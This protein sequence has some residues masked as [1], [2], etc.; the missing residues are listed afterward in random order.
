MDPV[1]LFECTREREIYDVWKNFCNELMHINRFFINFQSKNIQMNIYFNLI[2][3]AIDYMINSCEYYVDSSNTLY[4]ARLFDYEKEHY[5]KEDEAIGNIIDRIIAYFV[6]ASEED[7][8]SEENVKYYKQVIEK[9]KEGKSI[10]HLVDTEYKFVKMVNE[11]MGFH[12]NDMKAP[13]YSKT[14]QGRI[15]PEGISYLYTCDCPQTCI[16][17][18]KP[19]INSHVSIINIKPKQQLKIFSVDSEDYKTVG[20]DNNIFIDFLKTK[21]MEPYRLED[22]LEYIPT[23]FIAE[24]VKNKECDGIKHPSSVSDDGNNVIIF[25]ENKVEF[26]KNTN[27]YCINKI[28]YETTK[29]ESNISRL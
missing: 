13:P 24:Y 5:K 11:I 3:E 29:V 28:T 4:R 6:K 20:L 23:Q 12:P 27:L 18:I 7:R 1:L 2:F 10:I 22:S 21:F 17:E 8:A 15:N 9:M 25:D 14:K 26:A 16:A 19:Y